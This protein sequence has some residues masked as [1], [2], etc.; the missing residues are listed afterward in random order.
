MVT[1]RRVPPHAYSSH[2]K[3]VT[4]MVN[5]HHQGM[6]WSPQGVLSLAALEAAR[7]NGELDDWRRDRALPERILPEQG[8][9]AA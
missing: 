4:A 2:E 7:R 3:I 6:S 5:G 8:R 9:Q 1:R